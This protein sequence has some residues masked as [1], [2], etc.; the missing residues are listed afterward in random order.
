[1]LV[2]ECQTKLP[3]QKLL[4]TKLHEFY[5]LAESQ[6]ENQELNGE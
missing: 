2:L 4:L 6:A 5:Q 3:D 1:V